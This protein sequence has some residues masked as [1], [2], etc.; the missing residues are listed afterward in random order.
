MISGHRPRNK[1]ELFN[2]RHASARNV[3]ERIFGVLKQRFRILL[4]PPSYNLAVQ[5]R[6]PAALSALHNFI[7]LHEPDDKPFADDTDTDPF[8]YQDGS[9]PARNADEELDGLEGGTMG[10]KRDEIAA[11]MWTDYQR[12]L[13]ERGFFDDGGNSEEVSNDDGFEGDVGFE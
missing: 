5:S 10:G 1:E 3:I 8:G 11:A 7:R 13:Q 2:L 9:D 6:I 4:L 12:V